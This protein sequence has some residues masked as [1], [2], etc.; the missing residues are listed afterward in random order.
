MK[1]VVMLCVAIG[2]MLI[3]CSKDYEEMIVGTWNC[4]TIS[5][6]YI[7]DNSEHA[8][9]NDCGESIVFYSDGVCSTG[10][11]GYLRG[12]RYLVE[13]DYLVMIDDNSSKRYKLKIESISS[14]S[15]ILV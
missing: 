9:T 2:A 5:Y 15:C 4:V 3:S 14:S 12:N 1:K 10:M 11:T 7:F 8:E 13:D 6:K